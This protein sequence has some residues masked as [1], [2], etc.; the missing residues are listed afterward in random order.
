MLFNS[1]DFA[2]FLPIVFVLYWLLTS[3][4]FR[5]QNL[6]IVTASYYFYGLWDWRFL[7][8]IFLSTVVDFFVG[9]SLEKQKDAMDLLK[10]LI[11]GLVNYNQ[12]QIV[13]PQVNKRPSPNH[14]LRIH[15]NSTFGTSLADSSALKYS[16]LSRCSIMLLVR[17]LGNFLMEKLKFST[18][19]L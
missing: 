7:T 12:E 6:L 15:Q 16:F 11:N 8:L 1:L 9:L 17:E 4:R 10:N 13:Q 3:K 2:L 18:A 19:L 5:L 14:D